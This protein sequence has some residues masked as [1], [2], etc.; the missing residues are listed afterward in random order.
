MSKQAKKVLIFLVEG[1]TDAAALS[2]VMSRIY[3]SEKVHFALFHGD[4]TSSSGC[5]PQNAAQKVWDFIT[6]EMKKYGYHHTDLLRIVHLIDTDGAFIP[7][8]HVKKGSGTRIRYTENDIIHP[9]PGDICCMH[10]RKTAVVKKLIHTHKIGRNIPYAI[11]YLSRNL[12]HVLHN[13]GE[14]L[15][16][17]RKR[18]LADDFAVMYMNRPEAFIRFMCKPEIATKVNYISS[19]KKIMAGQNS[20]KRGSNLNLLLKENGCEP[21]EG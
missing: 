19:W 2:E 14:N 5:T 8:E 16:A 9:D 15:S 10:K 7:D 18:Q 12:E 3:S 21:Q 20:L 1:P 13:K 4:I 11:Y 6:G 17:S